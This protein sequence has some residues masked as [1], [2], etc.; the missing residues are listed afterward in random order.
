MSKDKILENLINKMEIRLN[1]LGPNPSVEQL[2]MLDELFLENT[3][4]IFQL[5]N[6]EIYIININLTSGRYMVNYN[7]KSV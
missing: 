6:S 2:N 1:D 3:R 5:S 7:A 4:R